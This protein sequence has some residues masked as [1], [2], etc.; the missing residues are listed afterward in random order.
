[1]ISS[2]RVLV[3]ATIQYVCQSQNSNFRTEETD[4]DN[5]IDMKASSDFAA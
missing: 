4:E 1:M 3:Q 2:P 5:L